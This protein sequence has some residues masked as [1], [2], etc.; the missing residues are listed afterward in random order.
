MPPFFTTFM[1]CQHWVWNVGACV[2][3]GAG[4]YVIKLGCSSS[5]LNACTVDINRSRSCLYLKSIKV[6]KYWI[7]DHQ[8]CMYSYFQ[9]HTSAM[10]ISCTPF[11]YTCI[12]SKPLGVS[13]QL[14]L[15]L[16]PA[17]S[18]APHA[19]EELCINDYFVTIIYN[20][21]FFILQ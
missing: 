20:Y 6:N 17:P 7:I 9:L 10:P 14:I 11:I 5:C 8:T 18:S 4:V 12:Y 21:I 15:C 13:S 3:G 2:E 19:V 16:L 1:C